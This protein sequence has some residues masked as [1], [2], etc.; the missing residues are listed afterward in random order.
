MHAA[1]KAFIVSEIS[2]KLRRAIGSKTKTS[3]SLLYETGYTVYFKQADSD[4]RKGLGSVIGR[5][6]KQVLVKYGGTYL[7]NYAYLQHANQAK[8]LLSSESNNTN[9]Q[10]INNNDKF[11]DTIFDNSDYCCSS[12]TTVTEGNKNNQNV[13]DIEASFYPST[14]VYSRFPPKDSVSLLFV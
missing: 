9:D 1:C 2:E 12:S 10:S 5:E 6:D 3:T 4:L 13:V 7:R 8:L 11:G 14:F